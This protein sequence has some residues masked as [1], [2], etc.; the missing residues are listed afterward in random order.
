MAA[1]K[2]GVA[3]AAAYQNLGA[4][5]MD[6]STLINGANQELLDA[7]ER[8]LREGRLSVSDDLSPFMLA[9]EASFPVQSYRIDWSTSLRHVVRDVPPEPDGRRTHAFSARA[10]AEFMADLV[11]ERGLSGIVVAVG[12]GVGDLAVY[13]DV[14][15]VVAHLSDIASF[16]Q[17]TYLFPYPTAIWCAGL[18][19][20]GYVEFGYSSVT[21]FAASERDT[22][23]R[24][25]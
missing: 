17:H 18:M 14:S 4:R 8:P 13:G 22:S 10:F 7:L 2:S 11:A 6:K 20:E 12:D 16:P 3:A 23:N 5:C 1:T 15:N 21:G 24:A 25:I 9:L 19:M